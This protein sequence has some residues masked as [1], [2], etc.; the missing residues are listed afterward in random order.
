MVFNTDVDGGLLRQP[1]MSLPVVR[2][3]TFVRILLPPG[4]V[5][6]A[7]ILDWL[8]VDAGSNEPKHFEVVDY[9]LLDSVEN[10]VQNLKT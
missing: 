10:L 2:E 9:Q 5:S 7:E 4:P 3:C 6:V 1:F 8:K